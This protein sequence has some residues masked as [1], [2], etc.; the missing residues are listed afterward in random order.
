MLNS[1]GKTT[2]GEK[3]NFGYND[4]RHIVKD[5][6]LVI[7]DRPREVLLKFSTVEVEKFG[8]ENGDSNFPPDALAARLGFH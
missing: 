5:A 1:I 6:D 4:I 8:K 2:H 3:I 7:L